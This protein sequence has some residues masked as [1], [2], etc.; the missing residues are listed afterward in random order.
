MRSLIFV[1]L[2][3]VAQ[4]MSPMSG[5]QV[6]P[7][8]NDFDQFVQ[9]MQ[10]KLGPE[11]RGIFTMFEA[12]M[13][14]Q[15]KSLDPTQP[16]PEALKDPNFFKNTWTRFL[17]EGDA[18]ARDQAK[19]FGIDIVPDEARSWW[20]FNAQ[21]QEELSPQQVK[22]KWDLWK[23]QKKIEPT[24][25]QIEAVRADKG[26]PTLSTRLK[27]MGIA[28]QE[29][30]YA[31]LSD[32][33]NKNY[34]ALESHEK[35][36]LTEAA[37]K[38]G[39]ADGQSYYRAVQIEKIAQ[40]KGIKMPLERTEEWL[41]YQQEAAL[42]QAGYKDDGG[43][44][45]EQEADVLRVSEA[46]GIKL[47]KV[48]NNFAEFIQK[49]E[50]T[51][52]S[53]DQGTFKAFTQAMNKQF[54]SFNPQVFEEQGYFQN[55]WD[56]FKQNSSMLAQEQAQGISIEI[57]P[58]EDR[59]WWDFVEQYKGDKAP[60]A[61]DWAQWKKAR[62]AEPTGPTQSMMPTEAPPK[63]SPVA[64][65]EGV[66]KSPKT[67]VS[68]VIQE[69]NLPESR[70]GI[71]QPAPEKPSAIRSLQRL[72]KPEPQIA[73]EVGTMPIEESRV[74]ILQ[75]APKKPSSTMLRGNIPEVEVQVS[76]ISGEVP[77]STVGTLKGAP[78]PTES[79]QPISTPEIQVVPEMGMS[80]GVESSSTVR[81]AVTSAPESIVR[82]N[83]PKVQVA[84]RVAEVVPPRGSSSTVIRPAPSAGNIQ[85]MGV[86]E[87]PKVQA[88]VLS[89]ELPESTVEILQKGPSAGEI[90]VPQTKAMIMKAPSP[91]VQIAEIS[92]PATPTRPAPL[93]PVVERVPTSAAVPS[94]ASLPPSP[95][96]E[97]VRLPPVATQPKPLPIPEMP[98]AVVP[99]QSIPVE[100]PRSP[101][102]EPL[103]SIPRA[104]PRAQLPPLE[105]PRALP[106]A[107]RIPQVTGG[108][109]TVIA[110]ERA[111][112]QSTTQLTKAAVA[113]ID[114]AAL[115]DIGVNLLIFI[116][117]ET[118][119]Y[120]LPL[121]YKQS[122]MVNNT[123][124]EARAYI[125]F[126]GGETV[127]CSR[128]NFNFYPYNRKDLGVRSWKEVGGDR[129]RMCLPER[130]VATIFVPQRQLVSIQGA[131]GNKTKDM[132]IFS[133]AFKNNNQFSINW[134]NA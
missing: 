43:L 131:Y 80:P 111:A 9:Y 125:S 59:V 44:V 3:C 24:P 104:A 6:I 88:S 22:E 61:S 36:A 12:T 30:N 102:Q 79:L 52:Q 39:Y 75:P 14:E 124:Y 96:S 31:T 66:A 105:V 26:I 27:H 100:I 65:T 37:K 127:S 57:A 115:I 108:G 123:L 20:D 38:S 81:Q 84:P 72:S 89:G 110:G 109:S 1:F 69:S 42:K 70:V 18:I 4:I 50:G 62:G 78:L 134:N 46:P 129:G 113:V 87:A 101:L 82:P 95:V 25:A 118:M 19:S 63:M 107:P 76:A 71:L 120:W 73:S 67:P 91:E 60:T 85:Q 93:P 16:L 77:K 15:F 47:A 98:R 97:P 5:S 21:H 23:A 49:T 35:L 106:S 99:Q 94:S 130:Y 7:L 114:T 119:P 112:A 10:P 13:N 116:A 117:M 132:K 74:G 51:I 64:T 33:L 8:M 45:F 92:R 128:A 2:I 56:Y 54:D 32:K 40:N 90:A 48:K 122:G 29:V 58:T 86:H 53:E 133:L 34:A 11:Q 28:E 83:V 103:P 41:R 17:K 68:R 126:Q 121:I 55:S